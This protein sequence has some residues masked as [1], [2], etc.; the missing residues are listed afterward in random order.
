MYNISLSYENYNI[1]YYVKTT[2]YTV[3]TRFKQTTIIKKYEIPNFNY[4]FLFVFNVLQLMTLIFW[5]N[6]REILR[7]CKCEPTCYIEGSKSPALLGIYG[8]R[9]EL[10][11]KA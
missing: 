10:R 9:K 8:S 2:L 7:K 5:Y 4:V 6:S 1:Y 11:N 3:S